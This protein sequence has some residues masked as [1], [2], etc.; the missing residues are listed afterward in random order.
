RGNDTG[1]S[2]E[3][4]F[5]VQRAADT[6]NHLTLHLVLE[7]IG[8]YDGA[9]VDASG[10]SRQLDGSAIQIDHD[11]GDCGAVAVK[12][13]V[14]DAGEAPAP[15]GLRKDAGNTGVGR[16]TCLQFAFC[17]TVLTTLM[18]RGSDKWRRRYWM[19]SAFRLAAISSMK[20]SCANV[21]C[22]RSGER[23]HAVH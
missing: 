9:R 10:D 14:Q 3:L 12:P 4:D 20:H 5:F 1:V 6:L 18:K 19:G 13:F 23:S 21:F 22:S 17:A 11:L 7:A 8:I 16:R 15:A 2:V